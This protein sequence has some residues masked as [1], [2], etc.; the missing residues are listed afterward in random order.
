MNREIRVDMSKIEILTLNPNNTHIS[1]SIAHLLDE[2]RNVVYEIV[3]G[4]Y[5]TG[6]FD[7]HARI[8][9]PIYI[10]IISSCG[11]HWFSSIRNL[12]GD[13]PITNTSQDLSIN[14]ILFE[15]AL[16][17]SIMQKTF[18]P[19]YL[20]IMSEIFMCIA[21][22][23][24]YADPIDYYER[25]TDIYQKHYSWGNKLLML[26]SKFPYLQIYKHEENGI[27]YMYFRNFGSMAKFAE[28]HRLFFRLMNDL[29]LRS[30]GKYYYNEKP[31]YY[32]NSVRLN[33]VSDECFRC[34]FPK[35]KIIDHLAGI[36]MMER[37]IPAVVRIQ[38]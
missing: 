32:F 22:D 27:I 11:Y 28:F 23:D 26:M 5:K 15:I 34:V 37:C 24:L 30:M 2:D 19:N 29:R 21:Q 10:K 7:G 6:M 9:L 14:N 31:T 1:R 18:A 20:S 35:D 4:D 16:N 36:N 13:L 33:R 38:L 12:V 3:H 17:I 8:T 25:V